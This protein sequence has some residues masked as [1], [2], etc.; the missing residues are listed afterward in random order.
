VTPP[1]SPRALL[2]TLLVMVVVAVAAVV[3]AVAVGPAG[4]GWPDAATLGLRGGRVALAFAVGAA[5][6]VAGAALQATLRNS[7]ADPY[8]LGVSGG[9]ALGAAAVT[10]S[11][12]FVPSVGAAAALVGVSGG[13]VVGAALASV[14]LLAFAR[15]RGAGDERTVLVGVVLNAFS[16]AFVSVVR[17]ALPVS[18]TQALS[19]WLV[20]AIGY[21]DTPTLALAVTATAAGVLVLGRHAG[22]L[23][24]L[25]DGDDEATRLGVDVA[26]LRIAVVGACTL[27]VGV[28]VASTGVIGFVGLLV[29]HTLRRFGIVDERALIPACALGGGALLSVV[30]AGARGAFSVLGTEPPVGAL[31]ALFGSPGFAWLLWREGRR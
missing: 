5:L 8:V 31:C 25:R 23:R 12:T 22:A 15:Q 7:L 4:P 19:V 14:V 2:R 9:A 6:S 18:S 30:D 20:G 21:P 17:A 11:S 27:L 29:P 16:W 24:L 10:A 1:L 13:G 28:A 26:T 3:V